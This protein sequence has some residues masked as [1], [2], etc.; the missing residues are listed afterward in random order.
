MAVKFGLMYGIVKRRKKVAFY[1]TKKG[2]DREAK[3]LSDLGFKVRKLKPK[4]K[5]I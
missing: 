2:R 3:V 1:A 4:G 5:A